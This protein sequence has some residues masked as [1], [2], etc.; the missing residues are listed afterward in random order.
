MPHNLPAEELER[1]TATRG[2]PSESPFATLVSATFAPTDQLA[3]SACHREHHGP[4]FDLTAIDNAACQ[5]CHQQRY[6]SFAADHP[7]FGNWPYQRRSRIE[8]NHASHASK[9]FA[10]RKQAFDCRSCHVEDATHTVQLT[11]SYDAACA[12]CHDE[13]IATS[14][15]QGVPIFIVPTLD[16]DALAAAGHDIGP[17]PQKAT[18]DFDGRLPPPMK[19]LLAADAGAAEAMQTLGEDFEF[20][21]VDPDDPQ[22]LAACAVLAT[23]IKRLF[24]D[25]AES[26][27]T[28][29]RDRLPSVFGPTTSDAE[30]HALA[31]GLSADTLR[32]ANGWIHG[33]A[34]SDGASAGIQRPGSNI[35]SNATSATVRTPEPKLLNPEPSFA[36]GGAWFLDEKTLSIRYRPAA[37]ADPVLTSWLE[38]VASVHDLAQKPLLLAT[39]KELSQPTAAGLCASCHSIEQIG[40]GRLTV[41]WQAYDGTPATRSFTKFAHGPHLVLPQLTDC[42]T[43]H[44]IDS[45]STTSYAGWEA[46]RFSSQFHPISK[47]TCTECHTARAAGDNCQKCHNYHVEFTSHDSLETSRRD[48]ASTDTVPQGL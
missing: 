21:D 24:A 48:T 44:V 3:C 17:W 11:A 46:S 33:H 12:S 25:L 30:I 47:Q 10:E 34:Q 20:L 6:K 45:K 16:V 28:A 29:L 35:K 32:G 7:D 8:F 43:C 31:A 13:R 36:P 9:H 19:L 38:L 26:R 37:H 1:I 14:V 23:A 5:G 39:F 4:E 15:A 41:N 27:D 42:T 40:T 22:Q 18:D 2:T